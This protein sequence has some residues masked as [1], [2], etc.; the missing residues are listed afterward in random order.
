[1]FLF[2]SFGGAVDSVYFGDKWANDVFEVCADEEL[3][4]LL[5]TD[6]DG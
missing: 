6:F 2:L 4:E 1:M 3:L 5:V